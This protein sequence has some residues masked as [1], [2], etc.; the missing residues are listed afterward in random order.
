MWSGEWIA[1]CLVH[2]AVTASP[3]YWP[4][5]SE[6]LSPH[7]DPPHIMESDPPPIPIATL[8]TYD[9][10]ALQ[11]TAKS[12][13]IRANQRRD[14]LIQAL[15]PRVATGYIVNSLPSALVLETSSF[16]LLQDISSISTVCRDWCETLSGGES[17]TLWR[18][19]AERHY[20][21]VLPIRSHIEGALGLAPPPYR[22]MVAEAA[23]QESQD[24]WGGIRPVWEVP[25]SDAAG[26]AVVLV[27]GTALALSLILG[28]L[29]AFDCGR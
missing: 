13:G 20:P 23:E 12:R 17:S 18:L 15:A 10:R 1:C 29:E 4:G 9:Y 24:K 21:R 5:E 27:F 8:R 6:S 22:D 14:A 25:F 16:L 19:M 2:Q 3:P 11:A 28:L 26:F 7:L